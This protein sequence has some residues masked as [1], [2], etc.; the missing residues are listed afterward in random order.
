MERLKEKNKGHQS[1]DDGENYGQCN[2]LSDETINGVHF[3]D[4]E[5]ERMHNFDEDF[6]EGSSERD[7]GRSDVDGATPSEPHILSF[8]TTEME[9]EYVIEENYMNDELD[10]RVEEDSCKDKLVVIMFNEEE[11]IKK[12]FIF[13]VRMKFSSLKKFKKTILEYNVLNGRENNNK[14][15]LN[16]VVSDGRLRFA[17]EITGY[18]AFKSRKIARQIVEGDSSKQYS[19]LWSYGIELRMASP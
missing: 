11:P 17:T 9:E 16:G 18:R 12:D 13:K 7:N 19:L 5:E 8:A 2:E 10:S 6:D 15:K 4:S 1:L 3:K 14:M